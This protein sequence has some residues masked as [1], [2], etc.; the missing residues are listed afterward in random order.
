MSAPPVMSVIIP[1]FQAAQVLPLQLRALAT[2]AEAP[3]FELLIVDN[4]SSDDLEGVVEAHRMALLAGG[5]TSVSVVPALEENGAS[6]ARNVGASRAETELLVFCDADDCVSQ[7]WLADALALFDLADAF[8][9]SAIPVP[10]AEFGDDVAVLRSVFEPMGRSVPAVRAQQDLA[11]PILMGGDF[12]MRRSLFLELGGFD[13]SLPVAGEDNDLAFR[14]RAA[15]HPILDSHSMRIGYRT[16]DG[17]PAS[18]AVARRAARTHILL[19]VRYQVFQR[20]AY[21]GQGRLAHLTL[22]VAGSAVKMLFLPQARDLDGLLERAVGTLGF[23]E[24]FVLYRVLRRAPGQRL[25]V[26]L[27]APQG[28]SPR[29]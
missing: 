10:A 6:Y 26:G 23:W 1:C 12:G 14:L 3:P 5:A 20:S 27:Q 16:R 29:S 19:C 18:R 15:G 24:G 9:G 28:H 25:G 21:V 13:Q 7:W 11:I 17:G 22:R 4:R 8:S 2:Q